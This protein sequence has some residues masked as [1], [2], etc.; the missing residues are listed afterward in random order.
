MKIRNLLE[1]AR[2]M[3]QLPEEH[4][5]QELA[6]VALQLAALHTE[7]AEHLEPLKE[8]LRKEA[9]AFAD[10]QGK[11]LI[12]GWLS[13]EASSGE[14]QITYPEAV[15]KIPKGVDESFL[16]EKLGSEVFES[17]FQVTTTVKPKKDLRARLAARTASAAESLRVG[18]SPEAA[19]PSGGLESVLTHLDMVE[20]TPRVGFRPAPGILLDEL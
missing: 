8:V 19:I 7:V 12:R 14:V 18:Y 13:E 9:R 16:R 5:I 1:D 15:L 17:A 11:A 10:D 2:E 3:A 6:G 20:P 4:S